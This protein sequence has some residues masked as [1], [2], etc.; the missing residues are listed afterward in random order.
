MKLAALFSGGKDSMYSIFHAK[1]SGHDI[2]CLLTAFP[3]S[4]NS[5]L[6]HYENIALTTLQ[7]KSM[8]IPLMRKVSDSDLPNSEI[9][10]LKNLLQEAKKRFQINGLVHGGIASKFQKDTF[11][12]ICDEL[13]LSLLSPIWEI[14][15][16][17]YMN[18][19]IASDFEF[20]IT[21][22]TSEGLDDSWLGK[23]ISYSDLHTLET[24]SKKFG[25]N[26][27]FEGGE[28]ETFI[29]NC[30]LFELPIKITKFKKFWDGYRGRFEIL[31][32][33][34]DNSVR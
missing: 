7:S 5:H 13:D 17:T 20:M 14:D 10:L 23:I 15:S 16:K 32:A 29:V 8:R 3:K 24:L 26:L 1:N 22:V 6:L 21:S 18:T 4:P 34:L 31:E 11:K 9:L 19:L 27:N 28:A 12:K 33:K 25:F 2:Q 30:P